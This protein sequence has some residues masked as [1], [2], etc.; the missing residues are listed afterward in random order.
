VT[1]LPFTQDQF[2]AV[3]AAYNEAIWPAQVVAYL[4]G[5]AGVAVVLAPG[6]PFKSTVVSGVLA[7]MWLWTGI[8][9][10]W[11]HF[12]AINNAAWVS[13]FCSRRKLQS[14]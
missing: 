6:A 12:A 9:Y 4:A 13:P 1:A 5:V 2:F 11:F 3:F 14:S 8:A 7:A 10:H